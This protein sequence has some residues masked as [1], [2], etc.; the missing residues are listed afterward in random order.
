MTDVLYISDFFDTDLVGGGELNDAELCNKFNLEG[1]N[2]D[3]MK[4]HTI[5]TNV[6]DNYDFFIISNFTHI[7]PTTL[8]YISENC[9][10][11]IYEHDHK[12]VVNRNPAEFEN[13]VAPPTYLINVDFYKNAKSVF[14]Q[15]SFHKQIILKNLNLDNLYVVS[16][17]LWSEESLDLISKLSQNK[18]EDKTSIMFS[19][20]PHKNTNDCVV[21]C[22]NKNID[23][24][25]IAS[26]DYEEF[27][28][29]LS[30]NKR[31]MFLPKTPETLSRVVVEARMLGVTTITN[32]N[33]GA[34]HEDWFSIKG[35]ALV[36]FMR[37]KKQE[38]VNKIIEIMN[39]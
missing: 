31:F 12:Y 1:Y 37:N 14:C 30:K 6:C 3:K 39:E 36:D 2:I 20:H 34:C 26:D 24:E 22:E 33:V 27:L 32:K 23:Y 16:G 19:H 18:K 35:E 29:L 8:D 25:L 17:N 11:I 21:Y 4:S 38:V 15:S 9:K 28:T 10:Y 7:E 5:T 13:C